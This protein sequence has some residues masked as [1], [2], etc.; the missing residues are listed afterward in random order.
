MQ[1]PRHPPFN[2]SPDRDSAKL[3]WFLTQVANVVDDNKI[4]IAAI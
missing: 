1:L 4:L 2:H 3:L